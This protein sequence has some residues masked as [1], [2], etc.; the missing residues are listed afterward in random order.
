M[1]IIIILFIV[2]TVCNK[3]DVDPFDWQD[4]SDVKDAKPYDDTVYI[5]LCLLV[6]TGRIRNRHVS[7][8]Q[9]QEEVEGEEGEWQIDVG[10]DKQADVLV[11]ARPEIKCDLYDRFD[12]GKNAR[13]N[14]AQKK[15][16][17]GIRMR[18]FAY[19]SHSIAELVAQLAVCTEELCLGVE[20]E[21][22]LLIR[23]L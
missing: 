13:E 5:D 23:I 14:G 7:I 9:S 8:N 10:E 11:A 1:E 20:E 19:G 6:T 2:S 12:Q 15:D 3:T 4:E 21:E 17:I 16:I 18:R 22:D